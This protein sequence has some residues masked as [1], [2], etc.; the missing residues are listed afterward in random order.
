MHAM[1][2]TAGIYTGIGSRQTPRWALHAMAYAARNLASQGWSLRSGAARGADTAFERGAIKGGGDHAIFLPWRRFNNNA[3]QRF[4]PAWTAFDLA[5]SVHPAWHK[6]GR[7]AR[8][9]HARNAH[10]IL[11][12]DLHTPSDGVVCWTP[13]GEGGGGTGTAIALARRYEIP[14]LDLGDPDWPADWADQ[15][16][17]DWVINWTDLGL[18]G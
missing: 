2:G 14:V 11:G 7:S 13:D 9:L 5:E 10:Q 15:A 18:A 16:I 3:S 4:T 12:D 17:V 8:K 1:T 6:C